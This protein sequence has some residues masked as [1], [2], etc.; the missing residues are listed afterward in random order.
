MY[1]LKEQE[2]IVFVHG[3]DKRK[4]PLQKSIETLE[5]Y[6]EKLKEYTKNFMCVV[7]VIVIQK[8]IMMRLLCE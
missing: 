6:L 8:L 4:N 2:G 5:A 7:A 3:T 1:A